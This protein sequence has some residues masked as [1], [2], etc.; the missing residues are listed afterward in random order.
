[1]DIVQ[2]PLGTRWTPS[3][4]AQEVGTGIDLSGRLAVVTGGTSGLG[5]ETVRVLSMLGAHVIATARS[6]GAASALQGMAHVETAQLELSDPGSIDGF[7]SWFRARGK[8]LDLLIL[9]AGIMAAPLTRDQFG[10]ESQFATNHLGHFRLAVGLWPSLREAMGARIVS[11]S[12]RGHQIGGFDL[13]DLGFEKRPYNKWLAYGQSKTANSLFAVAADARGQ[14]D[15]IRA[16]SV[17]PGSIVGPLARHL[18]TEEI[19]GFG[20]LSEDGSPVIDPAT[21]KK[22]F[23][24]GAA[25]TVWCATSADLQEI[26]GVYCENSDIASVEREARKGVR[27]YAIDSMIAHSLW[28][29]SV[30]LTGGDVS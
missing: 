7:T 30:E 2:R 21:D 13:E 11:L 6:T 28:E 15:G 14:R 5:L 17:H 9:N 20:A 4:T 27:P 23:A 26:G 25:T 10:N 18:T 22:T 1:M 29:K 19:A 8:P 16:Y 3:T 24:Q 12:S